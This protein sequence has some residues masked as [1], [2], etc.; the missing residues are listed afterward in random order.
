MSGLDPGSVNL[1]PG[2]GQ[3]SYASVPQ[4]TH[5]TTFAGL[6]MKGNGMVLRKL[7]VSS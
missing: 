7:E 6:P 1:Q 5:R 4:F 3:V 2:C